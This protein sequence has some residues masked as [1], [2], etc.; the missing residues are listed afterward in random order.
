MNSVRKLQSAAW[1]LLAV[2]IVAGTLAG[3]AVAPQGNV[4]TVAKPSSGL[5]GQVTDPAGAVVV[6]ATVTVTLPDGKTQT[7]VSDKQGYYLVRGVPAGSVTVNASAPGFARYTMPD[8]IIPAGELQHLDISF[9]IGAKTEQVTVLSEAA[10]VDVNPANNASATVLKDKD[11][12]ALSDDP[13][14]LE[15]D[16][17]ALAGPSAG[18]NGGQIYIDGF[19]NGTLPPKSAIREVRINQNPFSAA[20]D[21]PGFGRVEVFTKPGTDSWHGQLMFNERNQKLNSRNPYAPLDV[22]YYHTERYSGNVGG[23]INKKASFFVNLER[24]NIQDLAVVNATT[25]DTENAYTAALVA[26]ETRTSVSP[27]LDW[28]VTNNNTLSARYQYVKSDELNQGFGNTTLQSRGDNY[29]STEHTLQLS[30]TQVIS[31]HVINETRFQLLRDHTDTLPTLANIAAINVM[32]EFSAGGSILGTEHDTEYNY[33][34]QNYTSWSV[35]KHFVKF[36]GRLRVS[37]DENYSTDNFN[38]ELTFTTINSNG[39]ACD[40]ASSASCLSPLGAYAQG[41]ASEYLLVTGSPNYKLSFADVGLY[42]EDDWKLRPNLT[43]SYGMRFESQSAIKDKG[44]FGPR[45]GVSWGLG[46]KNS[47]PQTVLRVGYG[48]FYDRFGSDL[49]LQAQRMNGSVE[50]QTIYT[51]AAG[52]T[53][54]CPAGSYDSTGLPYTYLSSACVPTGNLAGTPSRYEINPNLRTPYSMQVATSVERQ[55]GKIGTVSVTYLNT[56]GVHQLDARNANAPYIT[57]YQAAQGNVYQ[58]YSEG[59]FKQNQIIANVQIRVSQ[60][61]SLQGFYAA[62]WA[63]GDVFGS[64]SNP[65]NSARLSDDYGRTTYDVRNRLFLGGSASLKYNIRLSPFVVAN[66]GAPFN[67][68]TGSDNNGDSFYNDRPSFATALQCSSGGSQYVS[69]AFGCFNL[70]PATGD[71]RIPVN[72]GHGPANV[73]VNLRVSKTFGF[74]RDLRKADDSKEQGPGGPPPGSHGGGGGHGGPGGPPPG[75]GRGPGGSMFAASNTSRH[76]NLTVAAMARNLFNTWN[77]GSPS[78]DLTS[79]RFGRSSNTAG[80]PFSNGTANRLFDLSATFSF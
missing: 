5:R 29:H 21:R 39:S 59:I 80:G 55:L 32:G 20:Y 36:G 61:F 6:G 19:S 60:I 28:Q 48:I 50:Q 12:E 16:L 56:R 67:I 26:P 30:D 54:Q 73:T 2:L 1:C 78:G 70:A 77:A 41:L 27:R 76:Y 13:D 53:I 71:K 34:V 7:T 65:S 63:N 52:Q 35:G 11:L 17:L 49:V 64:S 38:G 66:S 46:R 31:T 24:R 69:T 10:Q 8:V 9:A 47:T 23:G 42:A 57:G 45:V 14:E 40:A 37:R 15:Q 72:Y 79:S 3:Q 4:A 25:D 43:L 68:I 44:D 75:G 33:E 74:G 51:S 18:P 58:Y 62:G 22:P